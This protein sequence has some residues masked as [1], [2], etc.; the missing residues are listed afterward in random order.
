MFGFLVEVMLKVRNFFTFLAMGYGAT[1]FAGELSEELLKGDLNLFKNSE[2]QHQYSDD[3]DDL[4][5]GI[6]S[7][8][9]CA[10]DSSR[11]RDTW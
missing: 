7:S 4:P 5:N 2:C 3:V 9:I 1:S 11:A 10:G 6:I 8:Q